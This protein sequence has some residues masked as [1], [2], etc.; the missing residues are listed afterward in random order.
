MLQNIQK[1]KIVSK[2]DT[3]LSLYPVVLNS[4]KPYLSAK[5]AIVLDADSKTVIFSKNPL[6]RFSMASTAKIMTGLVALDYYKPDSVLVI[7]SGLVEG[8]GLN[9]QVGDK[10][11]FKD[12]LYAMLLPSANDAALA[13]AENYPGGKPA[14][15]MKM[16]EKAKELHLTDTHFEDPIGLNDDENYTTAIDLSRLG[17]EIIKNEE[18]A[19]I[20]S[21]QQ[22]FIS[23]ID[24]TQEYNVFNLNKLLGIQG[25]NGIKTGTTEGA[26]EVLLTSTF[27]NGHTY[28]IVVMNSQNRFS[29]TNTL[30]YYIANNVSFIDPKS[31]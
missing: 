5:A 3:T 12:L 30:L 28:I 20:V 17:S 1:E 13:I 2:P 25:V 15:V 19:Q 29:D 26:G 24:H 27:L 16:N 11:Y 18:L 9:L 31:K 22:K 21:T 10:F 6:L 23:N 4:Y 7:N 8:S 14:F